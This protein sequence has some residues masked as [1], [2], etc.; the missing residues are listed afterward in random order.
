MPLRITFARSSA[1][2]H[3]MADAN[4]VCLV[5]VLAAAITL[6]GMISS[7][8]Q[9]AGLPLIISA[10]VDYT[11]NTLT[12]DG[13]N[14]G[15]NPTVTLDSLPFLTQ[16]S[17]S[18]QI[19]AN[20][21]SGKAPSS[22]VPGTYFLTVQFRNQLPTIFGV[23]IGANGAPGAAGPPGAAGSPGVAGAPGPAGP[24][25]PQGSPGSMGP[26]GATGPSGATGA[27]GSPGATGATGAV[28]PQ[29]IAGS[30]GTN[31]TG[32][33]VCAASDSVVSYQG[34][35]ACKSTVPRYVDNGDG[36]VTDNLT[37][38]MW[39]KKTTACSGEITCY[40][41]QYAWT[42][43]GTAA[44]GS[45]FTNFLATLN[46]GDYYNPADMLDETSAAGSCLANHCDWRIP[47][48]AELAA[49]TEL[50]AACMSGTSLCIDPVLEPIQASSYWSSSSWASRTDGAWYFVFSDAVAGLISKATKN[51]AR[52]VRSGR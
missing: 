46:G 11:H 43:T 34:A 50:N 39:E 16:S 14:F 41:N 6:L 38:L 47:T 48:I 10:T 24:A 15:S 36:T 30:N 29:G 3:A 49:I 8:A 20:F 27:Q 2:F 32:A 23:D 21:P 7:R 42:S 44:D 4:R 9:A 33:P 25:G 19:V 17:G 52:A 37:G 40:T 1:I 45:L 28:G 26:P 31:G 22:F 35:L 51:Y 13:Q 18:N 5:G 12:I